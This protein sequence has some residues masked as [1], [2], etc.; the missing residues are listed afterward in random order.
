MLGHTKG[1]RMSTLLEEILEDEEVNEE[2][3]EDKNDKDKNDEDSDKK[4]SK[5]LARI[6]KSMLENEHENIHD[7]TY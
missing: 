3:I 4:F 2:C 1:L 6:V 5:E 7:E